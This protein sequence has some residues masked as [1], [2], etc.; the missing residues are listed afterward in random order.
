MKMS[1]SG[2]P[3]TASSPNIQAFNESASKLKGTDSSIMCG[4][5]FSFFPVVADPVNVTTSWF[6]TW[7]IIPRPNPETNCKAPS[8]SIFEAI[9]S[10]TI[11][12]VR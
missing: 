11:I 6:V 1:N 10:L 7:S 5:P 4:S 12:S 3:G 8:G 9:I 2:V